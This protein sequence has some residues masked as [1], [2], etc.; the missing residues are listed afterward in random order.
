VR[1]GRFAKF[2]WKKYRFSP[3]YSNE[4]L[5]TLKPPHMQGFGKSTILL[6]LGTNRASFE[7]RFL[8][9]EHYFGSF[10]QGF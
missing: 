7:E 10:I 9:N 1:R 8:L 6:I 2:H 3:Y 4:L 5:S